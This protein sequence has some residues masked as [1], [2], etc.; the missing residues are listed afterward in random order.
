MGRSKVGKSDGKM[1]S[2]KRKHN[3][4]WPSPL[5]AETEA[6]SSSAQPKELADTA[7]QRNVSL[8]CG[9]NASRVSPTNFQHHPPLPAQRI[10]FPLSII[11]F[12][13]SDS[14][15][16]IEMLPSWFSRGRRKLKRADEA[17]ETVADKLPVRNKQD[18]LETNLERQSMILVMGV[19]GSGK[20]YFINQLE[21]NSVAEGHGL[22]SGEAFHGIL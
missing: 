9:S 7:L 8:C 19:T 6:L 18:D 15:N 14:D 22:R 20:S 10:Y 21:P 5:G 13:L 1:R 11:I 4:Y 16:R 12:L 3:R 17:E 2:G